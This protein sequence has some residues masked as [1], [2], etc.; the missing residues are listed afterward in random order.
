MHSDNSLE[1]KNPEPPWIWPRAAYIHIPFCAH[2]CGYCD[3]AVAVGSDHLMNA[4]LDALTREMAELPGRPRV[5][6]IFVGG[7]TPSHLPPVQLEKM[8]K[9]IDAR[10]ALASGTEYS[11]EANPDSL[12]SEKLDL[13]KA[14][15][16][17]RISLGAQSFHAATLRTLE[18]QHDRQAVAAAVEAVQARGLRLSLDLIFG[19]PGQSLDDWRADLESALALAPDH[20][21]TY[22]LTYEKGTRLWRQKSEGTVRPLA[23]GDELAMYSSAIDRLESAGFEH[24]EISSFARPG[25]RCRHNE[26]YW[27]NHGY[28]GFGMGAARY[29]RGRRELNTRSLGEYLQRIQTGGSAVIQSEALSPRERAIETLAIQLRRREGVHAATFEEQTG[30]AMVDVA[31]PGRIRLCELNLIQHDSDGMRLTR[32]G[33]YVADAVVAE[34]MKEGASL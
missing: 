14:F 22:G 30:F 18:R 2:H 5:D 13:L 31:G 25:S 15:G 33:K 6:T 32:E 26:A 21:S 27:A 1:V 16:V 4:Y 17:N 19:V 12:S 9:L 23:E 29:V 34:F 20:L 7:G 8:L 10:F 3:F 24:Y 28:F 11:I